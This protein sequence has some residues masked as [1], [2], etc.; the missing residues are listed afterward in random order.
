MG[1]KTLLFKPRWQH[2]DPAIRAREVAR[3][4]DPRLINELSQIARSDADPDVRLAASR[5]VT[6]LDTLFAIAS[7]DS[8]PAVS[9]SAWRQV[10][11]Q[12]ETWPEGDS[13]SV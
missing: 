11:P 4:E 3:S 1:L 6:H 2:K 9:G 5:R 12:L 13:A 10:R 7:L 8:A